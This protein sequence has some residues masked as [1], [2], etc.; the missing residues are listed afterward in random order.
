MFFYKHVHEY[1]V[2]VTKTFQY[3]SKRRGNFQK[4]TQDVG[5]NGKFKLKE[6][7]DKIPM[8]LRV[9]INTIRTFVSCEK[10]PK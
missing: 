8:Q 2:Q 7:K 5:T 4:Y 3:I 1:N 6:G 9:Y 10:Y